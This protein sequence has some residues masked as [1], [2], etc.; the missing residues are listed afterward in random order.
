[1]MRLQW[2]SMIFCRPFPQVAHILKQSSCESLQ[3]LPT[4]WVKFWMYMLKS[5]GEFREA[6]TAV[7]LYALDWSLCALTTAVIC[8]AQTGPCQLI[9]GVLTLSRQRRELCELIGLLGEQLR[10]ATW[11]RCPVCACCCSCCFCKTYHIACRE[12]LQGVLREVYCCGQ[13]ARRREL[14]QQLICLCVYTWQQHITPRRVSLWQRSKA[15]DG[16]TSRH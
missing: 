10:S 12:L 13:A 5:M 7:K 14:I 16:H 6:T 8:R 2:R 4:W 9:G 1:M 3:W 15:L 11:D